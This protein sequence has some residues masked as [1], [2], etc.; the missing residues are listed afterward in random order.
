MNE[1]NKVK[2]AQLKLDNLPYLIQGGVF[3]GTQS[4]T[5]QSIV[6]TDW[7]ICDCS[8]KTCRR[9]SLPPVRAHDELLRL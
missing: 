5:D 8:D 7:S 2:R 3:I 6:T 1:V 4:L 9:R